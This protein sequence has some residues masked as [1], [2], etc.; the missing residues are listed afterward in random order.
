MAKKKGKKFEGHGSPIKH[1]SKKIVNRS[2]K[3]KK[4]NF[5]IKST[6]TPLDGSSST[7]VLVRDVPTAVATTSS[8]IAHDNVATPKNKKENENIDR[9]PGFIFM[10]NG[11][12]KAECYRN[13]VFGLPRGQLEIV[14]K[15]KLGSKLFLFDFDL[16]LLYG[17]YK[18]TSKGELGLVPTAFNGK[19]PAQVKNDS[20]L[21]M[22]DIINGK[23]VEYMM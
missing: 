13:R 8:A 23:R 7:S 19:F 18:A 4:T 12:T 10:C 20:S 21:A 2:K 16:K 6:P 3:R 17:V 11:K 5:K 14:E 1:P 22:V 15:I 9:T